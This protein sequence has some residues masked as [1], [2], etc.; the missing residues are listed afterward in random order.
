MYKRKSNIVLPVKKK[1]KINKSI[2]VSDPSERKMMNND[3]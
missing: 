1:S 3:E 2:T